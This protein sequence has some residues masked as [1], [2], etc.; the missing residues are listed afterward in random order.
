[1]TERTSRAV[2]ITSLTSK[3]ESEQI[4]TWMARPPRQINA[5]QVAKLAE[6]GCSALEIATVMDCSVDTIQRRFAANFA[7]GRQ[8]L[9]M[10]LRRRQIR[11]ALDGNITML[12]W[13]GKQYLGQRE[14]QYI[15]LGDLSKLSDEQLEAIVRGEIPKGVGVTTQCALTPGG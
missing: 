8:S 3:S 1:V 15:E 13:L 4:W 14:H 6:I 12:I 7:K 10:K 5:S 11:A 9:K 2:P